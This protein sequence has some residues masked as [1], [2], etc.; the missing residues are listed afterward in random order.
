MLKVNACNETFS[1]K[2]YYLAQ[3]ISLYDIFAS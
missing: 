3:I 2:K 1:F